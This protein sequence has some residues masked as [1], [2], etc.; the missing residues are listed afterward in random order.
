[1]TQSIG[2]FTQYIRE[3]GMTS[4]NCHVMR[5]RMSRLNGKKKRRELKIP[6][7]YGT[8]PH[9]KIQIYNSI[10]AVVSSIKIEADAVL[11]RKIANVETEADGFWDVRISC[12]TAR[13]ND[14][15]GVI[16][17]SVSRNLP[18]NTT[19]LCELKP[20]IG[21]D[22]PAVIR[23]IKSYIRKSLGR[24]DRKDGYIEPTA[25]RSRIWDGGQWEQDWDSR[26][27][28]EETIVLMVYREFNASGVSEANMKAMFK[29]ANIYALSEAEILNANK[30][31]REYTYVNN[32]TFNEPHPFFT[33]FSLTDGVMEDKHE[34]SAFEYDYKAIFERERTIGR[35]LTDSELKEFIISA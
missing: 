34:T 26:S 5:L 33:A 35:L 4:L 2:V 16:K 20:V 24:K 21:D 18:H 28:G 14:Y 25:Y 10:D 17:N 7:K 30:Y 15:I 13:G 6:K 8:K 19:F 32:K 27:C 3:M 9:R 29:S 23:Q 12:E 22:F 11:E 1:M 31:I